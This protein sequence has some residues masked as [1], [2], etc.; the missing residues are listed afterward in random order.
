MAAAVAVVGGGISG[1]VAAHRLVK[2]GATVTVVEKSSRLGGK[3]V[4]E[5][6]DGFLIEGGPDSFVAGKGSVIELADELGITNRVIS[7]RPEHR[8]SHVWWDD[9]LHPLPGGLL[10]MVPS[11]L[12]PLLRS[13]LLS[14]KSVG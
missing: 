4:T 1:L 3:V 6:S 14:W 2:A 9:R 7:T 10:L 8:G 12:S 13:S 11:R 5:H